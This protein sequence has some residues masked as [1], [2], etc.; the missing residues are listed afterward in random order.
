MKIAQLQNS[1]FQMQIEWKQMQKREKPFPD[2]F[3]LIK[4]HNI[5]DLEWTLKILTGYMLHTFW[6]KIILLLW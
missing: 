6:N 2:L 1:C 3:Y 4:I 5:L